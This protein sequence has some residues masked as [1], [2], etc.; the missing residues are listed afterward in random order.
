M[1]LP[2]LRFRLV[3][4]YINL[5]FLWHNKSRNHLPSEIWISNQISLHSHLDILSLFQLRWLRWR[6]FP[7][8]CSL[9]RRLSIWIMRNLSYLFFIL[10]QLCNVHIFVPG[11]RKFHYS[12][13]IFMKYDMRF[14]Y[15]LNRIFNSLVEHNKSPVKRFLIN[16]YKFSSAIPELSY[17]FPE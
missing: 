6:S 12:L 17:F 3:R 8:G 1:F 11:N 4:Y 5:S 9:S 16:T 7:L 15:N 2:Q 14:S 13:Y 10:F